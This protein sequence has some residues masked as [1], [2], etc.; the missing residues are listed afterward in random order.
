MRANT[1]G[2]QLNNSSN[3]VIGGTT[4]ATRNVISG[5]SNGIELSGNA[6]VV[7]GNFIGTNAAGTAAIRNFT[8][9]AIFNSQFTDNLIGGTAAGAGNLISGNSTA[10]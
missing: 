7:Q 3:N 1:R 10:I 6:N 8:G 9:V 5:N 4:S 2:I